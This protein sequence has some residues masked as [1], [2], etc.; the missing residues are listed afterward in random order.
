[1][2]ELYSVLT[3]PPVS[4]LCSCQ[5]FP[6]C[7]T[8]SL[9]HPRTPT[10]QTFRISL[11]WPFLVVTGY[12]TVTSLSLHGLVQCERRFIYGLGGTHSRLLHFTCHFI[13]T[14]IDS[15]NVSY[16]FVHIS[17]NSMRLILQILFY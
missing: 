3:L 12:V 6:L 13:V 1:M 2:L 11:F 5:W 7:G 16:I 14:I 9:D 15:L 8:L 10:R 4:F 17:S